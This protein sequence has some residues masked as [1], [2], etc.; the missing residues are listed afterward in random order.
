MASSVRRLLSRL[1]GICEEIVNC[2]IIRSARKRLT[3][4]AQRP[5]ARDATMATATLPPGSLQRMVR[6]HEGRHGAHERST[7]SAHM[8]THNTALDNQTHPTTQ[9][10][11]PGKPVLKVAL[12]VH[13][14]WHVA[15][16]QYDGSSPKPPQRFTPAGLLSWVRKQLAQG[17]QIITCYEAGPFGYTL[18]RQLTALGVTN[19]V[20]RPRNWDEQHKQVKTDRT[21]ALAMLNALDRFVAGNRHALALV[22]V[23]TEAE[24]R[25][26]TQTRLRQS[27][28]RDLKMIAQRGRG[29][30]LQYGYRLKGRWHGAR[31]SATGTASKTAGK[32]AATWACA[33][34]RTAPGP[35]NTR[36]TSPSAATHAYDGPLANWPGDC[37]GTNPTT[38]S[39]KNGA[40]RSLLPRRRAEGRNNWSPRWPAASASIGGACKPDRPHPRSWAW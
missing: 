8:N 26:R 17:W 38:A 21:D 4:Q 32:S 11:I 10:P 37:C 16:I 36:A 14:A 12:D 28:H 22:R 34:A 6:K 7:L 20:I 13:L 18:H 19:Y 5:G 33:P 25:A 35:D 27:L 39:A 1:S 23:P 15:A 30:A 31:K 3:T 40:R 9:S 2:P 29:I 24:E